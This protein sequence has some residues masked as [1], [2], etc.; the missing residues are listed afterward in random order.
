MTGEF[1]YND[2]FK[3]EEGEG[4]GKPG[5]EVDTKNRAIRLL[6]FLSFLICIP[7]SFFNLLTAF[8]LERVMVRGITIFSFYRH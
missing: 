5:S 3:T 6:V 2:T 4:G 1:E 8:A 7:V